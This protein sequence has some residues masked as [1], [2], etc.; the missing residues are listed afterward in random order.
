MA[1]DLSVLLQT[2]AQIFDRMVS[3][4]KQRQ[5]DALNQMK[6]GMQDRRLTMMEEAADLSE[7]K[8]ELEKFHMFLENIKS[9]NNMM[10]ADVVNSFYIQTRFNEFYDPDNK[11]WA[12]DFKKVLTGKY[13]SGYLA[14]EAGYGFSEQN[15]SLILNT[16]QSSVVSKSD[17]SV[18]KLINRVDRAY[19]L[20][21][22]GEKVPVDDLD[23]FK[24]FVNMGLFRAGVTGADYKSEIEGKKAVPIFEAT[25][26][27]QQIMTSAG[28][29]LS[30]RAKISKELDELLT[31]E[32]PKIDSAFNFL[33][34]N[35]LPAIT[36]TETDVQGLLDKFQSL[37][38]V[39]DDTKEFKK[40]IQEANENIISLSNQ[41]DNKEEQIALDKSKFQN[42]KIAKTQGLTIDEVEMANLAESIANN[43][44]SKDSL[45]FTKRD[46]EREKDLNIKKQG[47]IDIGV[48]PTE[49][50]IQQMEKIRQ[51][52]IDQAAEELATFRERY[53]A[54]Q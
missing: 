43:S 26:E 24:G 39:Q 47:L 52:Q 29:V 15:A 22:S 28:N 13:K 10:A 53:R 36:S 4:K 38:V 33:Q 9:R 35:Q 19:R 46:V 2:T 45:F 51:Q 5:V 16:I 25:A 7:Q 50:N 41:I 49:E 20:L 31:D 21:A 54:Q 12:V 17:A 27:W 23:L 1:T 48:Q 37:Q 14:E 44:A 8:F 30:N 11:E 6:L 18:L 32:I 40:P 42:M 3:Q 34:Y